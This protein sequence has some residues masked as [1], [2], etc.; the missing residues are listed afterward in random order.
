MRLRWFHRIFLYGLTVTLLVL[1]Y[2][3]KEAVMQQNLWGAFTHL[4]TMLGTYDV[5]T[6]LTA[7]VK[8]A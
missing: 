3:A 6:S 2:L 7:P 4:L 5:T 1:S 8:Q